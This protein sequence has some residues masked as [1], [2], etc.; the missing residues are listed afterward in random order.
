[1]WHW[2]AVWF[3]R[4]GRHECLKGQQGGRGLN[5]RPGRRRVRDATCRKQEGACRYARTPD[6]RR[7]TQDDARTQAVS[8]SPSARTPPAA[9]PPKRREHARLGNAWK[10]PLCGGLR[11]VWASY[12]AYQASPS[13]RRQGTASQPGN[14]GTTTREPGRRLSF[15]LLS[16][17]ASASQFT[18]IAGTRHLCNSSVNTI[19]I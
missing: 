9:R 15:H 10:L 6:A 1:V 17:A 4:M 11:R 13:R 3:T 14:Q 19:G 8:P 2:Q 16:R 5:E 18:P 7:Q 12:Q